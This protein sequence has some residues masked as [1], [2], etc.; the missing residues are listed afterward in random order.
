MLQRKLYWMKVRGAQPDQSNGRQPLYVR[1]PMRFWILFDRWHVPGVVLLFATRRRLLGGDRLLHGHLHGFPRP[2]P[3]NLRCDRTVWPRQ[4]RACRWSALRR[5]GD[6]RQR[7]LRGRPA[8]M[9]WG[10]LQ[11]CLRSV[12]TDR[13]ARMPTG[14]WLSR[15]RRPVQVG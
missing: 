1:G 8:D 7:G 11:P 10:L 9:R 3:R 13:G 15:R 14:E 5:R 2:E 6:E 4:L 12:G